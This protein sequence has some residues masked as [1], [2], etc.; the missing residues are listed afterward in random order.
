VGRDPLLLSEIMTGHAQVWSYVGDVVMLV[1]ARQPCSRC[2]ARRWVDRVL[3]GKTP[4]DEVEVRREI[5][6]EL[7]AEMIMGGWQRT[8]D[9]SFVCPACLG[10]EQAA[11]RTG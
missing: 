3:H 10:R 6:A 7:R 8:E 2:S 9:D 4:A 5:L 11:Q 1:H